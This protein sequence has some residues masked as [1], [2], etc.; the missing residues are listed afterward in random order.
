MRKKA[1]GRFVILAATASKYFLIF[2]YVQ[3]EAKLKMCIL[4]GEKHVLFCVTYLMNMTET[5]MIQALAIVYFGVVNRI[6]SCCLPNKVK[7]F[8]LA[9]TADESGFQGAGL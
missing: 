2:M 9:Q 6:L 8:H 1:E 5:N 7:P 4:Y 3:A